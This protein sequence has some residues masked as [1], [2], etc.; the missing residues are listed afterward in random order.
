M[1]DAPPFACIRDGDGARGPR[2]AAAPG[3]EGRDVRIT[4]R[5]ALRR[6]LPRRRPDFPAAPA[7]GH[8]HVFRIGSDCR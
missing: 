5:D 2:G 1:E 4:V 8:R 3:D 6:S 7:R